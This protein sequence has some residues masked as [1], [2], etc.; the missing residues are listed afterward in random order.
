MGIKKLGGLSR[1][2]GRATTVLLVA[3]SRRK[4]V[5]PGRKRIKWKEEEEK[6]TEWST[7]LAR[8]KGR[9]TVS[10]KNLICHCFFSSGRDRQRRWQFVTRNRVEREVKSGDF[11]SELATPSGIRWLST[12][13]FFSL[14]FWCL[15]WHPKTGWRAGWRRVSPRDHSCEL[16]SKKGQKI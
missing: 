8:H 7:M 16:F 1:R 6:K 5:S 3:R 4:G 10:L 9:K 15:C 14:F 2:E 12:E 11:W 13:T